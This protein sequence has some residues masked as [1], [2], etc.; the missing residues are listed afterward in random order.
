MGTNG[1]PEVGDKAP[2]FALAGTGGKQVALK[3]FVGRKNLVLY[4]YPK[5][6]T[7]GCKV[8]ACGFRDS[9]GLF[10]AQDAVILGVSRDTIESHENFSAKLRLPFLLLSDPQSEVASA[11]GVY[12]KKSFMGR[13]FFGIHRTTFVIDKKG[14]VRRVYPKV[15]VR[16]HAGEILAFLRDEM[17]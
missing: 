17:S 1:M 7:P 11:Y 16:E 8:E 10:E 9:F 12:G 14:T 15:K 3:D 6:D 4:F 2:Q 13:E 5:D